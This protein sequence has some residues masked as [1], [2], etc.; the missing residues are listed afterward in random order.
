MG[1]K[2]TF[3]LSVF[4]N[5]HVFKT[6]TRAAI[7]MLA[8]TVLGMVCGGIFPVQT[9]MCVLISLPFLLIIGVGMLVW[10]AVWDIKHPPPGPTL[11]ADP[12]GMPVSSIVDGWSTGAGAR[13]LYLHVMCEDG[14]V[15]VTTVKVKQ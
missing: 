15:R 11:N 14:V 7:I 4:M 13:E 8:L 9:A 3:P 5:R 10:Q 6:P 2:T 1:Y 12:L